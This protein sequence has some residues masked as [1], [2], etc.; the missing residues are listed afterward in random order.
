MKGGIGAFSRFR[1]FPALLNSGK[2]PPDRR[3]CLSA[4]DIEVER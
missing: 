4:L 3:A 2:R 1:C